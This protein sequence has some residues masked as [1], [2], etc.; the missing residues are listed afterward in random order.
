MNRTAPKPKGKPA[1]PQGPAKWQ[2]QWQWNGNAVADD[3]PE[4]AKSA[5]ANDA[6][7]GFA[8]ADD[9]GKEKEMEKDADAEAD[10]EFGPG[11]FGALNRAR[12]KV[13]T[14]NKAAASTTADGA[15]A[16]AAAGS[17]TGASAVQYNVHALCVALRDE[18]STWRTFHALVRDDKVAAMLAVMHFTTH[19]P[20]AAAAAGASANG[21]PAAYVYG[22][23]V[24]DLL[25]RGEVPADIDIRVV[26]DAKARDQFVAA[27]SVWLADGRFVPTE[28]D[29]HAGATPFVRLLFHSAAAAAAVTLAAQREASVVA[30]VAIEEAWWVVVDVTATGDYVVDRTDLSCNNL[31]FTRDGFSLKTAVPGLTCSVVLQHIA[32]MRFASL[33]A[34]S[35]QQRRRVMKRVR[36]GWRQIELPPPPAEAVQPAARGKDRRK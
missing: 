17:G 6:G 20:S 25:V 27:L 18:R 15:A 10:G 21:Q 9:K 8:M 11:A 7:T 36:R 16:A 12:A 26:G 32:T 28:P 31:R 3:E 23:A 29:V 5:D 13:H 19:W 33:Q 30:A 1:K 24:R 22:G 14:H 4:N 2:W 35:P 34:D